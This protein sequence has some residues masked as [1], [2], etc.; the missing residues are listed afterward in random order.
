MTDW[1]PAASLDNLRIRAQFLAR[2]RQFFWQRQVLEVETPLLAATTATDVHL[3][4]LQVSQVFAAEHSSYYLQTSPEFAMKRL[5][6][7]FGEPLYQICKAF[8]QDEKSSRHNP[9]FTMLEWYRP[10]FSMTQLMDEV[11]ALVNSLMGERIISRLSYRELFQQHVNVDPH[12]VGIEELASLARGSIDLSDGD[13]SRDAYLQLLLSHVIEPDMDENC[14][15][16][17]FPVK[18]AALAVVEEDKLGVKVAKRFELFLDKLE[19]ANG[20]FE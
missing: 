17:D 11:E 20:Y 2:I 13:Y 8:R 10:G 18:Q 15:I 12:Q 16:F 6:A 1:K 4:S 3:Q 19:I 9:E 7:A 14:F 5:L